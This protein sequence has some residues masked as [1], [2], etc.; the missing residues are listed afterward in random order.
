VSNELSVWVLV[1]LLLFAIGLMGVGYKIDK[2]IKQE[3]MREV[4]QQELKK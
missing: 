2:A 3:W 4:I 1:L